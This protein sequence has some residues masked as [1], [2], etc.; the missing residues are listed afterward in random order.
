MQFYKKLHDMS[1][2]FCIFAAVTKQNDDAKLNQI[3]PNTIGNHTNG[4]L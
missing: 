3:I 1:C 2:D 4:L